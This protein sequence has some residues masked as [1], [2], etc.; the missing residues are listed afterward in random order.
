AASVVSM[1]MNKDGRPSPI[2]TLSNSLSLSLSLS[3]SLFWAHFFSFLFLPYNSLIFFVLCLLFFPP[4]VLCF[5]S[6]LNAHT[7]HLKHTHTHTHTL[8]HTHTHTRTHT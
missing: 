3:V 2:L 4:T 1:I 8:T 5:F 6:H 7:L